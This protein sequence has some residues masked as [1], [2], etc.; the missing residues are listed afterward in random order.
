MIRCESNSSNGVDDSM[1]FKVVIVNAVYPPEPVVS[2]QMGRDLAEELVRLGAR[3]TVLCPQPS[4]PMV[5]DYS[6]LRSEIPLVAIVNGISVVRLPSFAAPQSRLLPRMWESWSFG[7]KVCSY[8][9]Q[10]LSNVDVVYANTWPLLSQALLAR[11]C[12]KRRVPLILHV[13]DVYPESLLGKLPGF[14]RKMVAS[15]LISLDRWTAKQ[16]AKVVAISENIRRNYIETRGL[17]GDKVVA[18]PNWV[19][20]QR[21][22]CLPGRAEACARYG[23]PEDRFTFLYLG[24][25]G[26]VAGVEL[27]I[28]A[29][30]AAQ[31]QQSQLVIVGDGS[32]KAGCVE[33]AHRLQINGVQFVSDPDAA[34]V[35][36]LQSLGHICLLPLRRG[37]GLSSIPSKLMAYLLSSKPVLAT[38]DIESDTARC[39]QEA[40]CG[41]VGEPENV[42]WLTT[43]MRE[44]S[45][46]PNF[47]MEELGRNGRVYALEIFSRKKGVEKMAAVVLGAAKCRVQGESIIIHTGQTLL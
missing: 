14:I 9:R 43:K 27:L 41:W 18:I 42:A 45:S 32:A 1:Q 21:F 33:L 6:A 29:F 11:Y 4:R 40:R 37:A 38:V 7:R 23:V 8:L 30:H 19:D 26:P 3:V 36:L 17:V 28:E 44:V 22:E 25:I 47:E 35:P 31:L 16:A 12:A 15:P 24:N 10:H 2:A 20:E 39:I 34:N 13:Q 46:L 5:A